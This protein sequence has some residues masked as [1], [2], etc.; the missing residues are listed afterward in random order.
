MWNMGL[1]RLILVDPLR[2]DEEA[3]VRLATSKA[4]HL[5]E[6]LEI[7]GNLEEA[8][9]PFH[10]VLGTSA[11][12]GGLRKTVWSPRHAAEEI[13]KL[14]NE[15]RVALLFGPEDRGL[16]NSELRL[17]RAL[18]RIPTA[19][20]ASLNISQAVLIICY[21]ICIARKPP[22]PTTGYSDLATTQELEGMYTSLQ[23]TLVNIGL[24]HSNQVDYGMLKVRQFLSRL[25]LLHREVQMIRGLCRQ[26]EWYARSRA[27]EAVRDAGAEGN[28][29]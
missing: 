29:S 3:M 13:L 25:R 27:K 5:I 10:F 19:E 4:A 14:D 15:K 17:C 23:R 6:E 20:F 11:R 24:I 18:V 26:I 8:L 16:T 12:G 2:W 9:G 22:P 7:H 21:E 28:H 1:S